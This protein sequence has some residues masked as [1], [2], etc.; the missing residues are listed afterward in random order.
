[1][2]AWLITG[3]I[4]L[5][6]TV[7]VTFIPMLNLVATPAAILISIIVHVIFLIVMLVTFYKE[8]DN[9]KFL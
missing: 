5:V 4:L 1:M 7:I 2:F 9:I 6:G 3:I 8:A